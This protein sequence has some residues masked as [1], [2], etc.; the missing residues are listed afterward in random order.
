M[1][2][3]EEPEDNMMIDR[4]DSFRNLNKVD[5]TNEMFTSSRGRL[6]K[7]KLGDNVIPVKEIYW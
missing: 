4:N 2:F 6:Q 1:Y 3:I 5:L 7:T